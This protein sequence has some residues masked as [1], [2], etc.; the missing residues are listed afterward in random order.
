MIKSKILPFYVCKACTNKIFD[1]L[2]RFLGGDAT[3]LW[4]VGGKKRIPGSKDLGQLQV[5]TNTQKCSIFRQPL[6]AKFLASKHMRE[7]LQF[8]ENCLVLTAIRTIG[9]NSPNRDS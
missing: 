4:F 8:I 6:Q 1:D 3:E 7:A 2:F 9:I 5:D